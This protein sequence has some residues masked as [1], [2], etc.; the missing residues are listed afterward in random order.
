MASI[1]LARPY[2]RLSDA[3]ARQWRLRAIPAPQ[4]TRVFRI[5]RPRDALTHLSARAGARARRPPAAGLWLSWRWTRRRRARRVCSRKMLRPSRMA[6]GVRP[7]AQRYGRCASTSIHAALCSLSASLPHSSILPALTGMTVRRIVDD[8]ATTSA[9]WQYYNIS[10]VD[11]VRGVALGRGCD[12][13]TAPGPSLESGGSG[14]GSILPLC[15]RSRCAAARHAPFLTPNSPESALS[16][17]F[18]SLDSRL[19]GGLSVE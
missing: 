16:L 9:A 5:A 19:V 7:F 14:P 10:V 1:G 18:D 4:A 3:E 13:T 11:L 2:V 6:A 8:K 12:A 15:R 17:Y